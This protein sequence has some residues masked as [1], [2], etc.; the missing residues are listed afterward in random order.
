MKTSWLVADGRVPARTVNSMYWSGPKP[1]PVAV[2]VTFETA[3]VTCPSSVVRDR[4]RGE[5][6]VRR[7]AVEES[8]DGLRC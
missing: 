1:S 6:R 3:S 5:T 2:H 4:G 8:Q 7:E